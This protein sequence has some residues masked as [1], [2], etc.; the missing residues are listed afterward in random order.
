MKPFFIPNGGES[1]TT[2]LIGQHFE[3]DSVLT[4]SGLSPKSWGVVPFSSII[5]PVVWGGVGPKK[6][7]MAPLKN[8]PHKIPIHFFAKDIMARISE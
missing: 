7:L 1:W 5:P 2:T 4:A 6:V 3:N 8:V